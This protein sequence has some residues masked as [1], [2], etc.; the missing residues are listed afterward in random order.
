MAK[1]IMTI[2]FFISVDI[3]NY[4]DKYQI[5]VFHQYLDHAKSQVKLCIA[6]HYHGKKETVLFLWYLLGKQWPKDIY[7]TNAQKQLQPTNKKYG[8]IYI[9]YIPSLL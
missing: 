4:Q 3:N 1:K 2:T 6:P 5:L 8:Y 7:N 9:N